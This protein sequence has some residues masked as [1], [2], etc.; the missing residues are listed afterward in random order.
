MLGIGI[1][2]LPNVGKSTLFSAI[3]SSRAEMANYPF[4]T[5]EPNVGIVE[6]K[7]DRLDKVSKISNSEK[8]IY[9][10]VKFVDIAGLVK[11]ASKGAGLGN[12]FLSN[13]REVGAICHV[14]RCFENENIVH[15]EGSIDPIRDL[16]TIDIELISADLDVATKALSKQMKSKIK[17]SNSLKL[18]KSLK[19]AVATLEEME[20]L[21][22]LSKEN[23]ENLKHFQFLTAKPLMILTNVSENDLLDGNNYTKLVEEYAEKEGL[24]VVR[25]SS[26][27]EYEISQLPEEDRAEFLKDMGLSKPGLDK[28][29]KSG[30]KM[31]NL[32]NFFTSGPKE[33]RSWT[34]TDG[35]SAFESAEEIHTDIQRGFIRAEVISYSDFLETNGK[36]KERGLARLEGKEYIVKDADIIYFRFNV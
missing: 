25:I 16:E 6:M 4:C 24:E 7:D 12:K 8:T 31:L 3:T 35:E 22:K 30:Y 19:V 29:V 18:T 11:G 23:L 2:G 26:Q 15:V 33:T 32:I 20:P 34:I 5:I 21:R 36:P 9:S 17:D 14:L 28:V 13:I 1:V 10:T 27:I